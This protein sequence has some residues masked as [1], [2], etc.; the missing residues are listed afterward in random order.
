MNE[1]RTAGQGESIDRR[2]VDQSE[3]IRVGVGLGLLRQALTNLFDVILQP[4]IADDV[5][6][7]LDLRRVFL[8][9]LDVLLL[10]ELVEARTK[11][12]AGVARRARQRH[13]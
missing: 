12:V 3:F 7:L 9:D 5:D 4:G 8:A 1:N 6:L 11:R 10:R 13:R 2:L